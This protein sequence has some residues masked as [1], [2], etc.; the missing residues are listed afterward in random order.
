MEGVLSSE[1][2]L[3]AGLLYRGCP[4]IRVSP[5]DRFYCI[6]VS[7]ELKMGFTV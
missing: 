3:K 1:C 6:E 2:P 7:L 5:E 4:L